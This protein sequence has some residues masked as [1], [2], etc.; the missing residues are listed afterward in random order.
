MRK[1]RLIWM[2]VAV[3][4]CA[5]FLSVVGYVMMKQ[6]EKEHARWQASYRGI[7]E[8]GDG[9]YQLTVCRVTSGHLVFSILNK[10]TTSS[11]CYATATATG[12]SE[13]TFYYDVHAVK[14]NGVNKN[15]LG[16]GTRL[17]GN[18]S[19]GESKICVDIKPGNS[20]GKSISFQG[21]LKKK[22]KMPQRK[23]VDL[24]S[25]LGKDTPK[26]YREGES[27][28]Y[29]E[30]Q[31][32]KVSRVHM[33][34]DNDRDNDELEQYTVNE[35]CTNSM[36]FDL[37]A[38]LGSPVAEEQLSENR[39]KRVYEKGE[40]RY[41]FVTEA[42]GLVV[43]ADCQY[44]DPRKG[45]RE[46]DFIVDG[47]TVLR[48][49]GDY[50]KQ[51]K[52]T[53]PKGTK[54]IATGAFTVGDA[55]LSKECTHVSELSIP[56]DVIVERY[57][58]RNC[59]KLKIVLEEGWTTVDEESF[60]HMVSEDQQ[61]NRFHWV[62][63]TLPKSM[64]RLKKNAFALD[65]NGGQANE[66]DIQPVMVNLNNGLE[67]I[68]DD[69]LKG[70]LCDTIPYNLVE[71]GT[72]F[73]LYKDDY[74]EWEYDLPKTLKRIARSTLFSANRWVILNG[75][76]PEMYGELNYDSVAY[77]QD[78]ESTFIELK[79]NKDWDELIKRLCDGQKLTKKEIK[80]IRSLLN[81][82]ELDDEW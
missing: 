6:D 4:C 53:L 14:E 36:V 71:L 80:E 56:K 42:Y 9:Q 81:P 11:L 48:Y 35:I 54:R 38:K 74:Y 62:D 22:K 26:E 25:Y 66:E 55:T 17:Q 64:R 69:S 52:I 82:R 24:Q 61:M 75:D 41:Q 39:Y 30:Q 7:W 3:V 2:I 29:L 72:N 76:L 12:E 46:G 32:G 31:D 59:G 79:D 45:R 78:K 18:I 63:V 16:Y 40:Y 1:R 47:E 51:R 77:L 21:T 13:Y 5:L 23:K 34:W 50:E 10:K 8:S 43:E 33:I 20:F 67:Y 28:Y 44:R 37:E 60:S 73:I 49:L 65:T 57:A 58:F 70:I 19:L 68:E 27:P 15:K